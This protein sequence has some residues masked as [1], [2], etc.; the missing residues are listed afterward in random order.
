MGLLNKFKDQLSSS[1][2]SYDF[3]PPPHPIPLG[4]SAIFRYRK[5]RGVNLGS[6]FALERWICPEVFREAAQPGQSDWDVARSGDHAKRI[7]E[8]HWDTWVTEE[9]FRWIAERGFNSVRLP[10]AYYHL[11]GPLFEVLKGTDF[12]PFHHIFEGAWGRIKQAVELAGSYGLGVLIDLHGAAGAQNPDAHSGLSR[13]KVGFW[14]THANQASTSLALRF[15]A[16]QFASVPHVVGLELLNE[17]QNNSRL[18]GWY[19]HTIEGI[20]SVAPPDFPIYISD[21]WD[22]QHYAD[23]VGRRDDFVVLDHHLY[24]CFTGDDKH[25]SGIVHA[26]ELRGHFKDIFA[27]QSDTA[28]GAL[29]V[30]EWS[31]SLDPQ[32]F[33][34]DISDGE[35]DAQRREFVYSQ[36]ELFEKHAAGWWFWTYKKGDGWDAGWSARDASRAEIIPPWIGGGR[37]KGMPPK[38]VKD[39]ELRDGHHAH[40]SYWQA[41]GGSPDSTVYAPGFSQGWDDAL[42]FLSAGHGNSTSELGFITQWAARRRVEYESHAGKKLGK[43]A[44]EWEHGFK[45]G[46][47]AASRVCLA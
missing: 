7:L 44:W 33:P 12:E 37:F 11:C 3:P 20:R 41:N 31:A 9:D 40:T 42:I 32:S 2:P 6:W 23:Y 39:A 30:G 13:G 17:P 36:I 45:Q 1:S 43:A 4:P 14:D 24:R 26:K 25:K 27:G 47:D 16:S 19:T 34:Q 46:V 5:Q 10:I 35:K 15:L 21:A 29:V 38:E 28:K 22:T 18:Q 8:E